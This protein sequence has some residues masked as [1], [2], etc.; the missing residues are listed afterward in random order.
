MDFKDELQYQ[1]NKIYEKFEIIQKII[2]F[3]KMNLNI[4]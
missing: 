4:I 1:N 2:E 3:F